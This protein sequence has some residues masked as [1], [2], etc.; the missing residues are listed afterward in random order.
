MPENQET[1][2]CPKCGKQMAEGYVP[3]RGHAAV[4]KSVWVSGKPEKSFFG[5]VDID[6]KSTIVITT[7]RCLAC[8]FLES[9]A[10]E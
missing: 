1:K 5:G 4:Y 9:Y 6:G 3:D 2:T 10:N 8:G 7:F